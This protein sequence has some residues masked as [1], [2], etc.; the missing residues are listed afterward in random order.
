MITNLGELL[1]RLNVHFEIADSECK[2]PYEDRPP[3]PLPYAL[4]ATI[5]LIEEIQR[6]LARDDADEIKLTTVVSAWQQ[7]STDGRA[8]P[9]AV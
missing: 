7:R 8:K 2:G 6:H 1:V 5:D 4:L 3:H 9:K